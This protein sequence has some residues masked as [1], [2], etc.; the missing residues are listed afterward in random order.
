MGIR[1]DINQQQQESRTKTRGR[2]I[3]L[4]SLPI[5]LLIILA[6]GIFI[7]EKL[8]AQDNIQELES[9]VKQAKVD[10]QFTFFYTLPDLKMKS[11]TNY[12]KRSSI[13]TPQN[14]QLSSATLKNLPPSVIA[15]Q[16][17]QPSSATLKNLPPSVIAPQIHQPSQPLKGHSRPKA[18]D[19]SH[20]A[21]A[22]SHPSD[23]SGEGYTIQVA[24]LRMQDEAV[25]I[26]QA[27][28]TKGYSAYLVK[29]DQE[30]QR[31]LY[32]VR[33]GRFSAR[34]EAEEHL[35]KLSQKDGLK[36]FVVAA[37]KNSARL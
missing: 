9:Q 10:D 23:S 4:L 31:A 17:R 32:R 1:T 13:V 30:S 14:R 8:I 3:R 24:A 27:L 37:M 26:I 35:H 29:D 25:K 22:V 28:K 34:P 18:E 16:N 36:G 20:Q 6:L 5:S 33:I 2:S 12:R 7:R 15:S 19:D 11:C 21:A